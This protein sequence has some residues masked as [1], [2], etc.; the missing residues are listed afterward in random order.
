MNDNSLFK[1]K[2]VFLVFVGK[3]STLFIVLIQNSLR[4]DRTDGA[5]LQDMI[6]SIK[7]C[8]SEKLALIPD[9]KV[10]ITNNTPPMRKE[11]NISSETL[12]VHLSEKGVLTT[13][14]QLLSKRLDTLDLIS[15]MQEL[16]RTVSR[17]V[18]RHY[19][20]RLS[21]S[22]FSPTPV[23]IRDNLSSVPRLQKTEQVS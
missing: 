16:Q 18:R 7:R 6:I 23:Q 15:V 8:L 2:N 1:K 4:L 19:S 9:T 5:V 12:E 22:N 10:V 3:A 20:G 21:Y 17:T 14:L 13:L 11:R